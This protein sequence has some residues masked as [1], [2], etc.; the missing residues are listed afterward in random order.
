MKQWMDKFKQI[1]GMKAMDVST[2]LKIFNT[3]V[4]LL[5][6]SKQLNRKEV[7]KADKAI[8][9]LEQNKTKAQHEIIRAKFLAAKIR[10]IIGEV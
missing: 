4:K 6:K 3:A 2:I 9:K 10:D 5:N 1:F 8:S 7:K